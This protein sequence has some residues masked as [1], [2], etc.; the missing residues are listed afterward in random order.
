[1]SK[2]IIL[3][4]NICSLFL[5]VNTLQVSGRT[6]TVDVTEQDESYNKLLSAPPSH[7]TWL[8]SRQEA[9]SD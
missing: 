2:Q 1:M 6:V 9:V 3:F 8:E 7:P 4:I 5:Y